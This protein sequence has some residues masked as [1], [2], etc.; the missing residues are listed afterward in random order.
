MLRII[1]NFI[2]GKKNSSV[3]AASLPEDQ[4]SV[5]LEGEFDYV[6][7]VGS[8]LCSNKSIAFSSHGQQVV[9]QRWELNL[10]KTNSP[11]DLQERRERRPYC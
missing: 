11:S 5:R 7:A 4:D 2:T 9:T 10:Q 8:L 3:P 6:S 1:Q